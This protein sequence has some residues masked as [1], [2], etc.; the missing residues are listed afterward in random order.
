M[1]ACCSRSVAPATGCGMPTNVVAAPPTCS[2]WP[3][4]MSYAK[5]I[6]MTSVIAKA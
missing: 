1:L 5:N 3:K 2:G 4:L 6:Q